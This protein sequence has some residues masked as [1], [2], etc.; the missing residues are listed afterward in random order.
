MKL[1]II[2][3]RTENILGY[4][5]LLFY[6]FCLPSLIAIVA[7]LLD[8]SISLSEVN[9]IFFLVNFVCVVVIFRKF[10]WHSWR[11]AWKNRWHCLRF[12]AL[13]LGFY[14]VSMFLLGWIIP[15]IDPDFSNVNDNAIADLMQHNG[16]FLALGAIFLVPVVE[17]TLFRGLIFQQLQQK[18]R[19]LAYCI[20]CLLFAGIH[21]IGFVGKADFC[22]LLLCFVQYLPAGI[23]LAWSYEMTDTVITPICIHIAINQIGIAAMR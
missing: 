13:G 11:T 14:F 5:Y 9:I 16:A 8:Y 10:L 19:L 22:T 1:S 2:T 7:A 20:S 17:E 18:N 23:F 4:A 3:N 12:A 6:Q 15:K 21:I